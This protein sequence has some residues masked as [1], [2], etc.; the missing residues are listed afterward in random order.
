MA[1][2]VKIAN[3]TYNDVP[4]IQCPDA[5]GV[6]HQFLDTTGAN[7]TSADILSG[8]TAYVNGSLVTGALSAGLHYETG[9]WTPSSN[10]ATT[11]ISFS[12]AHT[13]APFF[14]VVFDS[15]N[16]SSTTKS[17]VLFAYFNWG[18]FTGSTMAPASNGGTRNYG[19]YRFTYRETSTS[20]FSTS[21]GD[22]T[23]SSYSGI[24]STGLAISPSSSRY[25][26]SGR[27]YK[28]IAVFPAND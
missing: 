12:N 18:A 21:N 23:A 7:A 4:L 28:W 15:G 2:Q 6:L 19:G 14:A 17:D 22:V 26:R 16:Y 27:S 24:T 5:N 25:W 8:K 11:A 20:S 9:T 3:V 1:Q 13:K 10:T